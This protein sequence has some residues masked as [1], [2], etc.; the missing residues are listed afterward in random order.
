LFFD[1]LFCGQTAAACT[2]VIGHSGEL[3]RVSK[4]F[5]TQS[6]KYGLKK[7]KNQ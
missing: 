6:K 5:C 7:R 1:F 4:R 2:Y 3:L